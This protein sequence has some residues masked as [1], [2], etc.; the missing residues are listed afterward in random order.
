MLLLCRFVVDPADAESFAA[1]ADRALE[2]LTAQPTCIGGQLCRST[3]AEDHWV[4]IARF[5]SVVGYRRAMSPFEIRE[6]MIPL[7]ST[8]V[9][10]E[11]AGYEVCS[12]ATDGV[13]EHRV[14]LVAS[15][16]GTVRLGEAAGP[17]TAR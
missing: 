5:D 9:V 3:D 17:A 8:A 6:L 12:D 16:A 4:L 10:D 14:S 2:L 7:L 11:P 1:R 13:V 15:D